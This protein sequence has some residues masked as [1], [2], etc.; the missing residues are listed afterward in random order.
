MIPWQDKVQGAQ[1][2]GNNK[3]KKG[4]GESNSCKLSS[5]K[6]RARE[7]PLQRQGKQLNCLPSSH[8]PTDLPRKRITRVS[9]GFPPVC[10]GNCAAKEQ[11]RS[12]QIS[13]WQLPYPKVSFHLHQ[14]AHLV[15]PVTWTPEVT[16]NRRGEYTSKKV[17]F[18]CS[19]VTQ[20]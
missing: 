7:A 8:W 6:S 16:Q 11:A 4:G 12:A 19:P 15:I 9:L 20:V 18:S 13:S 1:L 14:R 10:P 3:K 5:M 17:F 2:R